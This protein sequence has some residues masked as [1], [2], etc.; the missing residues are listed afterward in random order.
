MA[1]DTKSD[2]YNRDDYK[3]G[4]GTP[5]KDSQSPQAHRGSAQDYEQFSKAKCRPTSIPVRAPRGLI[6]DP[7]SFAARR[8]KGTKPCRKRAPAQRRALHVSATSA[9]TL[10]RPFRE[11]RIA[12]CKRSRTA[13][14]ATCEWASHVP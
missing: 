9:R 11:E 7:T 13:R 3:A 14:S 4:R 1:R 5:V 2:N 12:R 10:D 8:S 6:A